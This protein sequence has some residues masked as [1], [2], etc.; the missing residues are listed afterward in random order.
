MDLKRKCSQSVNDDYDAVARATDVA[1]WIGRVT[2]AAQSVQLPDGSR[3]RDSQPLAR[4]LRRRAQRPRPM[5]TALTARPVALG[6]HLLQRSDRGWSCVVCKCSSTKWSTL[7]PTRCSG[8]AA[9]R[10]A[11]RAAEDAAA[12]RI[13][14]GGHRRY[15]SDDVVWCGRC[16]AYASTHAIGLAKACPGRPTDAAASS[17]LRM[18]NNGQHPVTRSRFIMATVPEYGCSWRSALFHA[19]V[20]GMSCSEATPPGPAQSCGSSVV[21]MQS[22]GGD[23]RSRLDAVRARVR[24]RLAADTTCLRC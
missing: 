9:D 23:A 6:G 24:A 18:L 22:H 5:Q 21:A 4:S 10:W 15:L 2:A 1:T 12:G 14:G 11:K 3:A 17:R 7:A 13:D 8:S 16:G 19:P 20:G